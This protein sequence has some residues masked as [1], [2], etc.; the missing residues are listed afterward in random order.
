[1]DNARSLV[2]TQRDVRNVAANVLYTGLAALFAFAPHAE[3]MHFGATGNDAFAAAITIRVHLRRASDGAWVF[4]GPA[5]GLTA[6][7]RSDGMFT[8][9]PPG[10]T[11]DAVAYQVAGLG[12]AEDFTI[13]CAI[14]YSDAF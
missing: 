5:L 6:A 2:W 7:N 3:R 13:S 14:R 1:M 12:A 10:G 8:E 11:Y 4:Y 9:I